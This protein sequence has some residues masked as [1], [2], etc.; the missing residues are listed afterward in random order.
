VKKKDRI[1]QLLEEIVVLLK[2]TKA[3]P[4]SYVNK[5]LSEIQLPTRVKHFCNREGIKTLNQLLEIEPHAF[6][7]MR[8]VGRKSYDMLLLELFRNGVSIE[9]NQW[10]LKF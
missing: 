5:P 2:P 1:I 4:V 8:N 6:L 10:Q 3:A 7:R 9:N